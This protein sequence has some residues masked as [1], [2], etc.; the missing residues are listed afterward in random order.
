MQDEPQA[1]PGTGTWPRLAVPS[2]GLSYRHDHGLILPE[3][4]LPPT[5]TACVHGAA[6]P[7]ACTPCTHI[8]PVGA[9]TLQVCKPRMHAQPARVHSL[10]ICYLRASPP[11]RA[12]ERPVPLHRLLLL[13][14]ALPQLFGK[15]T[16]IN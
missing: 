5:H 8:R 13:R 4:F 2:R 1:L 15:L 7:T 9:D 11:L 3:G 10:H 6:D 16:I 14:L 12:A